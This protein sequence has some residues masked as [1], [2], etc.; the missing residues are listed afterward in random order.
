M[1]AAIFTISATFAAQL[2]S[3][4]RFVSK[5]FSRRFYRL[6]SAIGRGLHGA[7]VG[8]IGERS[9]SGHVAGYG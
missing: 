8:I 6:G 2:Q 5:H 1:A 9:R 3:G 4:A 7:A